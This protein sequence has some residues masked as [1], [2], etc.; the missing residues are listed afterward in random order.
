MKIK[1]I[2]KLMVLV[3]VLVLAASLSVFAAAY[4]YMVQG[5]D[6]ESRHTVSAFQ[7][8]V[9]AQV[10]DLQDEFLK[11]AKLAAGLEELAKGVAE[12]NTP[13]LQKAGARLIAELHADLMTITDINGV[14]IAR[15]HSTK[16]GDSGLDQETV[17]RALKGQ[18]SV[19]IVTGTVV[20]FSLR[21]GAPVYW[22]GQ[23]VGSVAIGASLARESMVDDIKERTGLEVTI[24]NNDTRI[25]TTIITKDGKRA[26]GTTIQNPGVIEEVLRQGKGYN[27]V[28]TILGS[29]YQS[30]YWPIKNMADKIVGMWFIGKPVSILEAAEKN[31]FL[32]ILVVTGVLLP[33]LLLVSWFAARA[34]VSPIVRTTRFASAV[35]MGNLDEQLEVRSHDETGELA[36]SLRSMVRTLKEK[37]FEAERNTELAATETRKAQEAM[38][39]AQKARTEADSARKA[40]ILHAA[41]ELQAV[42]ENLS[43]AADQLSAQ[44]KESLHDTERQDQLSNG[45]AAAMQ[46]LYATIAESTDKANVASETSETSRTNAEEGAQV[47]DSMVTAIHNV[48]DIADSLEK[49]MG[50]LNKRAEEIGRVMGV[51]SDIADQTN[52]LALNAAIE[53]ARAG[54]A[55]RGF[56]VVAD[57]VRKLAEKTMLATKEVGESIK[58]IQHGTRQSAS[59]VTRTVDEIRDI[60]DKARRAGEALQKIVNLSSSVSGQVHSIAVSSREQSRTSEQ[61]SQTIAQIN[62]ISAGTNEGMRHSA[63]AVEQLSL[64]ASRLK[65]VIDAMHRDNS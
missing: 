63:T 9:A 33:L 61:V 3:G 46:A 65:N 54:D 22:Q 10:N 59:L 32:S 21:A 48:S 53:A 40:G 18:S 60:T 24:F 43:A 56:A 42:V 57:E 50:A 45:T 25:M 8:V 49:D 34:L 47:I 39:A 27:A 36:S 15:G 1:I 58:G 4:H 38:Q 35:A 37:I 30:Y 13:V 31:V 6:E 28:N 52:L 17:R 20:P 29:T 23:L 14:I 11:Q 44:I 55:G 7:R 16:F 62:Q 2:T 41:G 64:Q 12:G 26:L 19:G 5:F 51:I